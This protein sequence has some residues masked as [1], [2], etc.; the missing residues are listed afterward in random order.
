MKLIMSIVDASSKIIFNVCTNTNTKIQN[1]KTG[2][3]AAAQ[4]F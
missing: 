3:Q 4:F 1:G 2:M